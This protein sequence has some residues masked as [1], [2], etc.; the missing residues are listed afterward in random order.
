MQSNNTAKKRAA[1]QANLKK[2]LNEIR[3]EKA[4]T[5]VVVSSKP[6]PVAN[7]KNQ[8][9]KELLGNPI[10]SDKGIKKYI[11]LF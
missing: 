10:C 7:A 5:E 8:K 3:E 2:R 4:K 11:H 6:N 1:L 9:E